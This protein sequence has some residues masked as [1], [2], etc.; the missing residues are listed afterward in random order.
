MINNEDNE[1][2]LK[3]NRNSWLKIKFINGKLYIMTSR[4]AITLDSEQTAEFIEYVKKGASI[5]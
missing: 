4:Q 2:E 3:F 1:L 5:G